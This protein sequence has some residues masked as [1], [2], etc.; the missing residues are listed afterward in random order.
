[1]AVSLAAGELEWFDS[2]QTV[3]SRNGQKAEQSLSRLVADQLS[4]GIV[5]LSKQNA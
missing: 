5:E 2:I 4:L 1:M 3:L